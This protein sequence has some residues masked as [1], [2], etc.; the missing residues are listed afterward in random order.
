MEHEQYAVMYRQEE[1]HWWYRGMRRISSAL[2]DRFPPDVVG[3]DRAACGGLDILDAGCG[4]GGM[5][6]FL[7][8]RGRVTG[9]DIAPD[10]VGLASRRGLTRLVRGSVSQLPFSS[11]SFDL[12]T[13]FDVLYHLDVADDLAALGELHR[14]IRP[15]GVLLL[16]LPAYDWLRGAHDDAVHTRHR[17]TRREVTDKLTAAGFRVEHASYAN[18]LLLP[19]AQVKRL[20]EHRAPRRGHTDPGAHLADL[21]RPPGPL[22]R[23]L[24]D[25][26]ALEAGAVSRCAL[27]WG[28]SVFA[29]GRRLDGAQQPALFRPRRRTRRT[30]RGPASIIPWPAA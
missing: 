13:S 20:L 11:S 6:R 2:L 19:V 1:R 7:A 15:G 22:N 3:T 21:W 25:V 16:R 17:Y 18:A 8:E 14:V 5:S 12:V 24:T 9:I 26:L 23:L 10:A 4:S 29:V 27:P 28:L 30:S